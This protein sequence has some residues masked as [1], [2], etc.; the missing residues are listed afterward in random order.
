MLNE[1]DVICL[2]E[3]YKNK[4]KVAK[5]LN[6]TTYYIRKI[7]INNNIKQKTNKN[8]QFSNEQINMIKKQYNEGKLIKEIAKDF[9]VIPYHIA[10]ALDNLGIKEDSHKRKFNKIANTEGLLYKKLYEQ[11]YTVTEIGRQLNVSRH[12]VSKWLKANNVNIINYTKIPKFDETIFDCIDTEEKAYW[13]GFIYADGSISSQPLKNLTRK[14]YNFEISLQK[15]DMEHLYKFNKFMKYKGNHVTTREYIDKQ[16]GKIYASC[17]WTITNKHLWE[18]LNN[19]GCIPKKSLVLKFPDIS[20]FNNT[21]LIRHFIRGYFDGDGCISYYKVNNTICKPTCSLIGTKEFLNSIKELLN[22]QQ[23]I[24]NSIIH[25]D[26]RHITSNTYIFSI[27]NIET[28]IKFLNF[29]YNNSNVYLDRKYNRYQ[30]L[31]N[32]HALIDDIINNCN[33]YDQ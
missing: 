14:N 18:T 12:T 4:E 3:K 22:E 33:S 21:N 23:I 19:Y 2:Y 9:N 8:I 29:L 13:L 27:T 24:V 7:L 1:H 20:I 15:H 31:K 16:T 28:N 30:F 10:K 32:G 26:K 6:T 17:R 11:G 25:K 5:L